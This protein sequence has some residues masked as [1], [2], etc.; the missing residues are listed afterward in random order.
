MGTKRKSLD[1]HGEND[2][3]SSSKGS[4]KVK[5]AIDSSKAK[6]Q[7]VIATFTSAVPP[8]ASAFITYKCV[9]KEHSNRCIVVSET[10]KIEYV[11]QNFEDNKPIL[12]GCKY[13]VGVHDKATGT[14]TFRKAQYVRVNP[15]VKSLKGSLGVPD[16]DISS[17]VMEARN[18]LGEEFGSKKRKSQ[19]R[20]EE[21]NKI[22][23][24]TVKDS[25]SIIEASIELR[26]STMPTAQTIK[27]QEDTSRPVPKYNPAA[28]VVSEIYDMEDLLP[29]AV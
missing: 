18:E 21:R 4:N 14:V 25:K 12:N 28:T 2:A 24:D 26:S 29:K 8:A 10:E 3:G 27:E 22:N 20:A 17:R 1:H 11:G 9:D 16:R 5:I 23:M 6:I 19:L 13:L 15:V 7:P